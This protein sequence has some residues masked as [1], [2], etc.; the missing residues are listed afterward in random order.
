MAG[1]LKNSV[2]SINIIN[3]KNRIVKRKNRKPEFP[4]AKTCYIPKSAVAKAK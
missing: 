2:N 3:A 1:Q 4:L